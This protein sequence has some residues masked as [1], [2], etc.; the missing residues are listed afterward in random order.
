MDHIY[1][2]SLPFVSIHNPDHHTLASSSQPNWVFIF[3]HTIGGCTLV[4]EYDIDIAI[5]FI[6]TLISVFYR[7]ST[8][9]TAWFMF[10]HKVLPGGFEPPSPDPKSCMIDHYTTGVKR[11]IWSYSLLGF[12]SA[13]ERWE[14]L[15]CERTDVA[16]LDADDPGHGCS[17]SDR[18]YTVSFAALS[19]M[20]DSMD[21][22]NPVAR[23]SNPTRQS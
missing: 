5:N 22:S 17:P 23:T 11:L 8:P 9:H 2:S 15:G 19:G 4:Y 18:E 13:F 1:H 14:I 12:N 7:R 20:V 10:S 16:G 6:P 21:A 3:L